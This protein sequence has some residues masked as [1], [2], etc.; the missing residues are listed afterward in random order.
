MIATHRS[1]LLLLVSCCVA[2][3]FT[4]ASAAVT[5]PHLDASG[6][7]RQPNYPASALSTGERGAL[8]VNAE[9]TEA[10]RVRRVLL[11]HST[12]FDDLDRAGVE[13]ILGWRFVPAQENGKPMMGWAK[14]QVVFV[15]P[16]QP[17]KAVPDA[18]SP[19]T[20]SA[21]L[22]PVVSL[23][24]AYGESAHEAKHIPC[25][26]GGIAAKVKFVREN[27]PYNDPGR[28]GLEVQS[29]SERAEISV[30]AYDP[31]YPPMQG[32][33]TRL[34]KNGVRVS[35]EAFDALSLRGGEVALSLTW[36]A[37]G[38]IKADAHGFGIH[39]I[40][41]SSPPTS[42]GLFAISATARFSNPQLTCW[43][44]GEAPDGL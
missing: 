36:D 28:V 27:A 13:A 30:V 16:D 43:A 6:I 42:F 22:P 41:M 26:M 44:S 37:S 17:D 15:P 32:I 20:V 40:R 12:G 7:N 31:L 4:S 39:T 1:D 14:E 38:L 34:E 23:V 33:G 35:G 10:G 19:P 18:A 3:L 5:P 21:Y 2:G 9:I 24:A 25:A 29:G 8:I 11:L